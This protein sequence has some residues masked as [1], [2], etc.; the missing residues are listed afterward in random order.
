MLSIYFAIAS[1]SQAA[2]AEDQ[3]KREA[4]AVRMGQCVGYTDLLISDS[5]AD[6]L[7]LS[8]EMTFY[9]NVAKRA[10][11]T[12]DIKTISE[13]TRT[14]ELAGVGMDAVKAIASAR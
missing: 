11:P 1:I 5:R 3:R 8:E 9:W 13:R 14:A 10:D 2:T 12:A 6:R 7:K 4:L